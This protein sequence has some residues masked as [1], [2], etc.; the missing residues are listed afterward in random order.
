MTRYFVDISDELADVIMASGN[1]PAVGWRLIERTDHY[2]PGPFHRWL[3][4]DDEAPA[5]LEGRLV[6][7]S[8]R[9]AAIEGDRAVVFNRWV[10]D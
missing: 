9:L 8:F 10:R 1:D 4:E 3:V 6:D 5:E 2:V 7:P